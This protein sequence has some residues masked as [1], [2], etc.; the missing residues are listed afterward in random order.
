V[1]KDAPSLAFLDMLGLIY[2]QGRHRLS[3]GEGKRGDGKGE[4]KGEVGTGKRG[5]GSCDW[6]V[7]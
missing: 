6:A 1:E 2:V 3:W 7:K 5:G 4:R